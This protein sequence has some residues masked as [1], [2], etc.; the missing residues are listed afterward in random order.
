MLNEK[1]SIHQKSTDWFTKLILFC[2]IY[3]LSK[4][5]FEKKYKTTKNP[6]WPIFKFRIR[7]LTKAIFINIAKNADRIYT[8]YV[9]TRI[10]I[11]N[12]EKSYLIGYIL[13]YLTHMIRYTSESCANKCFSRVSACNL[14]LFCTWVVQ[15]VIYHAR[16]TSN[17]AKSIFLWLY[18]VH[19]RTFR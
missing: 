12:N 11:L 3:G 19:K 7:L 18:Q 9:Y 17:I 4:A 6:F 5:W 2:I 16:S 13:G 1:L 8:S 14:S 15:Y 10:W